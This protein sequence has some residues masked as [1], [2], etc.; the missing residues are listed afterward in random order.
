MNIDQY[1]E[2]SSLDR[3]KRTTERKKERERDGRGKERGGKEKKKKRKT[4]TKK[5]TVIDCRVLNK[6]YGIS[7]HSR[8]V[9]I[10]PDSINFSS[11]CC[12]NQ[13]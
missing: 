7:S 2:K 10:I 13:C 4:T 11:T 12:S 1:S 8:N 3:S 6:T 9:V 5:G